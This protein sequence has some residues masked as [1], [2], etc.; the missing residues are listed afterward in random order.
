MNM[1][2]TIAHSPINL[3]R[4]LSV[5]MSAKLPVKMA[6]AVFQLM[7]WVE[8]VDA[9]LHLSGKILYHGNPCTYLSENLH[10]ALCHENMKISHL[11]EIYYCK[12]LNIH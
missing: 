5:Q 4:Y 2:N 3:S 8:F 9:S 12:F 10:V 1:F 7:F 11:I 6:Y